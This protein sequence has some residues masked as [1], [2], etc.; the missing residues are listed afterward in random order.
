MNFN[1]LSRDDFIHYV[2]LRL[3]LLDENNE[4]THQLDATELRFSLRPVTPMNGGVSCT[5]RVIGDSALEPGIRFPDYDKLLSIVTNGKRAQVFILKMGGEGGVYSQVLLTGRISTNSRTN[6]SYAHLL[7]DKL[8]VTVVSDWDFI[9]TI[10]QGTLVSPPLNAVNHML[11]SSFML[12]NKKQMTDE[13]RKYIQST[14]GGKT[15]V[16]SGEGLNIAKALAAIIDYSEVNAVTGKKV[17]DV[18]KIFQNAVTT[19]TA[20]V[21]RMPGQCINSAITAISTMC[22]N[23][24]G[25]IDN[26]QVYTAVLG[27]FYQ[28]LVPRLDRDAGVVGAWKP[29]AIPDNIWAIPR[30][31]MNNPLFFPSDIIAINQTVSRNKPS[32]F[33]GVAVRYNKQQDDMIRKI[34]TTRL[35]IYARAVDDKTGK[36]ERI[37]KVSSVDNGEVRWKTSSGNEIRVEGSFIL[38]DLPAWLGSVYPGVQKNTGND[39]RDE[40]ALLVAQAE[41]A[42]YNGDTR[43]MTVQLVPEELENCLSIVG[44]VICL[45]TSRIKEESD[46]A[47]SDDDFYGVVTGVDFTITN[48]LNQFAATLTVSLQ[49]VRTGEEQGAMVIPNKDLFITTDP[50]V[51]DQTGMITDSDDDNINEGN[52]LWIQSRT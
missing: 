13:L 35:A 8:E 43:V 23:M 44:E 46:G 12:K 15:K 14:E 45:N 7:Q 37:Q 5:L 24:L 50:E 19:A 2:G 3:D 29:A 6:A 27:H 41:F 25:K 1:E 40:W 30:N 9:N 18:P 48:T 33:A 49:C 21:L 32:K 36:I 47:T 42:K 51:D 39:W 52:G 31:G 16:P 34:D 22:A 4:V 20:P 38:K 10:P 11:N 28:R 26:K 17:K